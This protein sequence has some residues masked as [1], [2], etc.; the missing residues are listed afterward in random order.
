MHTEQRRELHVV[1]SSRRSP[2]HFVSASDSR[3]RRCHVGK[4]KRKV[5]T[6]N[7]AIIRVTAPF[8]RLDPFQNRY[9]II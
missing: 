7:R 4:Y 3:W 6:V 1:L 9:N 8:H 5:R 2:L